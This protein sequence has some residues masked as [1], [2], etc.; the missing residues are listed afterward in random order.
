MKDRETRRDGVEKESESERIR[1]LV[2][3]C[4]HAF[5]PAICVTVCGTQTTQIL[6]N[7]VCL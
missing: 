3:M 7:R 1:D 6:D 4:W 2:A 5:F